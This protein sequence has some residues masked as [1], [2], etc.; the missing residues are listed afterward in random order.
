MK[1]QNENIEDMLRSAKALVPSEALKE[2]VLRAAADIAPDPAPKRAKTVRLSFT[3]SVA[4]IAA[5]VMIFMSVFLSV[6]MTMG[7]EYGSVYI[8]INP[9]VELV[10]NRKEQVTRV[11][12]HNR[13]AKKLFSDLNLKGENVADAM[14]TIFAELEENDYL[15]DTSEIYIS[16]LAKREQYT[17]KLLEYSTGRAENYLNSIGCRA[18]LNSTR[19]TAEDIISSR[20]TGVS[21]VK[22][23]LIKDITNI[24]SGYTL[25]FLQDLD[26]KA[27]KNIYEILLGE[28][29]S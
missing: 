5:S 13:D 22:F 21:P 7:T 26:M 11:V 2:K 25:D 18:T 20:N 14:N 10:I 4:I 12:Y 16:A 15:T 29:E 28:S 23:K 3:K 6:F 1:K 24:D 9:S 8:D 19:I 17:E 27:L